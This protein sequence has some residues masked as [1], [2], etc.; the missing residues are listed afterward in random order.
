MAHR[1]YL[2]RLSNDRRDRIGENLPVAGYQREILGEGLGYQEPVERIGMQGWEGPQAH[3]MAGCEVEPLRTEPYR[4][5]V[6]TVAES[7]FPEFPLY[8]DLR[9]RDG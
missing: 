1:I 2:A 3:R 5:R 6:A 8:L 7:Q 9:H 4:E